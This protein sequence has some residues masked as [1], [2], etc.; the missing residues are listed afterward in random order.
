MSNGSL[1]QNDGG[2]KLKVQERVEQAGEFFLQHGERIRAIVG[3]VA[4]DEDRADDLYQE[5]YLSLVKRPLPSDIK[6]MDNYLFTVLL[7]SA[8]GQRRRDRQ[9]RECVQKYA[10]DRGE[11]VAQCDIA[12]VV[13]RTDEVNRIFRVAKKVLGRREFEAV[14]LR[15]YEGQDNQDV[16]RQLG[17]KANTIARYLWSGIEK[18]RNF[19]TLHER[20]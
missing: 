5:F 7:N 15:Y 6:D 2:S 16:G 9:Y 10:Q 20:G 12:D 19:P 18:I 11:P 4:Q 8:R 17:L 13:A 3:Y 1:P 14:Q